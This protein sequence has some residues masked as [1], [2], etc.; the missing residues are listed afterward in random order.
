MT[1]ATFTLS[2]E[3]LRDAL[4]LAAQVMSNFEADEDFAVSAMVSGHAA[5][6]DHIA[7]AVAVVVEHA[8][9]ACGS[10]E[11]YWRAIEH[12]GVPLYDCADTIA[13]AI[14]D[15]GFTM[16]AQL[17][18]SIA[19]ACLALREPVARPDRCDPDECPD[20]GRFLPECECTDEND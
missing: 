17:A 7:E 11:Q 8:V 14:R 4:S 18:A 1:T 5:L 19:D 2:G 16:N 3:P 13:A 6:T 12:R 15:Q 10:L 20:C 9:T